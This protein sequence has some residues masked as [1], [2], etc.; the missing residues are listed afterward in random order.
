MPAPS[1]I[2]KVR[3]PKGAFH[4]PKAATVEVAVATLPWQPS[5]PERANIFTS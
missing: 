1:F 4:F 3:S 5:Q 2:G